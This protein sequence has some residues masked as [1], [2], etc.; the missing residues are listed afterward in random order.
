MSDRV[1][2]IAFI[3]SCIVVGWLLD[4][5]GSSAPKGN[6]IK[7]YAV[8][9]D[10][11]STVKLFNLQL[12]G[13][14]LLFRIVEVESEAD[15]SIRFQDDVGHPGAAGASYAY[16]GRVYI[17]NSLPSEEVDVTLMHEILHCAGVDHEPEDATS[18][19][20]THSMRQGRLKNEHVRALRRLP[21]ITYP[22]R[23]MI[24]L[25]FLF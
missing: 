21:G 13:E 9:R 11:R 7:L 25:G 2:A 1:L 3:L 16:S 4:V 19:M 23:I 20:Y 8:G 10:I 15:I 17:A 5:T 6:E 18:V 14:S 22:E 24:Q 12:A